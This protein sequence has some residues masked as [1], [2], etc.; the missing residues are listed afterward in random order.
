[1]S[2]TGDWGQGCQKTGRERS[3]DGG[4]PRGGC[5][6]RF[7]CPFYISS[8]R[9]F[10]LFHLKNPPGT[11]RPSP[12]GAHPSPSLSLLSALLVHLHC[13]IK[14]FY[15]WEQRLVCIYF[16]HRV[17]E[18]MQTN[19]TEWNYVSTIMMSQQIMEHFPCLAIYMQPTIP[20]CYSP[21]C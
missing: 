1:M 11:R 3:G 17:A 9:S 2:L 20:C 19:F 16:L 5:R 7:F 8:S 10:L 6:C 12:S 14:S 15:C 21:W 13:R 18:D 4:H